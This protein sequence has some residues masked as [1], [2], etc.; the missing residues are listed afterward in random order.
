M[1]NNNN[2]GVRRAVP[3]LLILFI[4][5]MLI[6][7][8]LLIS[9]Q[10]VSEQDPVEARFIASSPPVVEKSE[11]VLPIDTVDPQNPVSESSGRITDENYPQ[12]SDR[13]IERIILD[14]I[15]GSFLP[16]TNDNGHIR[17]I[18]S[19]L[20]QNGYRDAFLLVVKNRENLD[21]GFSSLSDVS[22]LL[23]GE[24]QPVDFFLSVFLQLKGGMISMFRIP[25]G[26][27]VV[28][29]DF[30]VVPIK[31]GADLPLGINISFQT[32]KGTDREWIIFS[33]YNKFSLF[34]MVEDISAY[35]ESYDI[36]GDN[37]IDIVDWEDGL[38]EG[39]GYE[40]YL[41]WYRWNGREYREYL[42][43]NIVRN[44]N[45]FLEQS[46]LYLSFEQ[47]DDFFS[48]SLNPEDS[49]IYRNSGEDYSYWFR[50]VFRPV[51][52]SNS[53]NDDFEDCSKFR[54]IVFPPI[55][56]NPFSPGNKALH[57]CNINVRF[58]CADGYSFIRT[59]RIQMNQN[60]FRKP[61]FSFYL[62]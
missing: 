26:S 17:I 11:V 43:T 42:S 39:T 9:C 49:K 31:E 8:S 35:S 40:T 50:K 22:H 32:V 13:E 2:T 55:F 19:D 6:I 36:D 10:S 27:S 56:E 46:G 60:P 7:I 54:S 18:Y 44:L 24:R 20:D 30:G 48:Y 45:G 41:T 53:E 14:T 5:P 25:I 4:V 1:R 28:I 16:V 47:M 52:G 38:E 15:P 12:L 37:I 34:S 21:A 51:P 61:Q 57:I 33:R 29:S 23:K 3:L 59:A 62:E 58:I